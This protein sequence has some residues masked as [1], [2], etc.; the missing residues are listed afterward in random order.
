MN[1]FLKYAGMIAVAFSLVGCC[2]DC[3]KD[4][5]GFN[6]AVLEN[7]SVKKFSPKV[8]KDAK[9]VLIYRDNDS[10][11]VE[12]MRNL[13]KK[14][15]QVGMAKE[16][17]VKDFKK[18]LNKL[19]LGNSKINWFVLS[20]GALDCT[21][22]EEKPETFVSSFAMVACY[23]HDSSAIIDSFIEERKTDDSFSYESVEVSKIRAVKVIPTK[24]PAV[25]ISLFLASL[26]DSILIFSGSED[27]LKRQIALYR[28]DVPG[29]TRFNGIIE[30]D[31]VVSVMSIGDLGNF[32][33]F[34]FKRRFS[35]SEEDSFSSIIDYKN[36][37]TGDFIIKSKKLGG[38]SF[39]TVID[40]GSAEE[41][42]KL[43]SVLKIFVNSLNTMMGQQVQNHYDPDIEIGREVL[44]SVQIKSEGAKV[45]Y[46]F[47]ASEEAVKRYFSIIDENLEKEF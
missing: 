2:D 45:Y 34:N 29:D 11:A 46:T 30:D 37:K 14:L 40:T 25:N 32:L 31:E 22:V 35:S 4:K 1:I 20:L 16:T 18:F 43:V 17:K 44:N 9:T 24:A 6:D 47:T 10:P 26:D 23:K 7:K 39:E 8:D 12:S 3:C 13:I 28:D 38:V 42:A 19:G 21:K 36:F 41:S 5:T 15:F 27:M 33:S